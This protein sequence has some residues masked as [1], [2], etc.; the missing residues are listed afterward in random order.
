L[1]IL[2]E[3]NFCVIFF[4]NSFYKPD[5][6]YGAFKRAT[7]FGD[8][9]F[10]TCLLINGRIPLWAYHLERINRSTATLN[11]DWQ[12]A[13]HQ[14]L[15]ENEIE[16]FQPFLAANYPGHKTFRLRI[17]IVRTG[18]GKYL[19]Q[20]NSI[21]WW[22]EAEPITEPCWTTGINPYRIAFNPKNIFVQTG[23]LAGL[24]TINCLPYIMAS[25]E[26]V[27][28]NADELILFNSTGQIADTCA[29]SIYIVNGSD[30]L[31][32]PVSDGA[33]DSVSR[34]FINDNLPDSYQIIYQSLT[35][36]DLLQAECIFLSNALRGMV[37]VA[38]LAGKQVNTV[39]ILPLLEHFSDLYA[40]LTTS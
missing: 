9:I 25:I 26:K 4:D 38:E 14:I 28:L 16:N 36:Q 20:S 17:N 33:L 37:P 24:K 18:E 10:E 1:F 21:A 12:A 19:P 35:K 32:P 8:G 7:M 3:R 31:S 22:L 39:Q 30:I 5:G 6:F 34:N 11:M 2:I 23:T 13:K 29:Y 15:L 27:R 40:S